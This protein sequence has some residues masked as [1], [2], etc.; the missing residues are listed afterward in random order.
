MMKDDKSKRRYKEIGSDRPWMSSLNNM[1]VDPNW[2]RPT[3]T[4]DYFYIV[5]PWHVYIKVS[6]FGIIIHVMLFALS[7]PLWVYH[8]YHSRQRA[9]ILEYLI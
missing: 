5:Q 6:H 1:E 8:V 2:T 3:T 9:F 7:A 4:A